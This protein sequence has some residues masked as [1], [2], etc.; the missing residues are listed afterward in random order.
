ML[1][2]AN[3]L[4]TCRKSNTESV[5]PKRAEPKTEDALARRLNLRKDNELPI[6]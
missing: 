6:T 2:K 5:D 1:R 4:P 3:P